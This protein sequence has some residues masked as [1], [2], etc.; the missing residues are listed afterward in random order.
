MKNDEVTQNLMAK[1][2]DLVNREEFHYCIDVIGSTTK[3]EGGLADLCEKIDPDDPKFDMLDAVCS[4]Y[5]SGLGNAIPT[6]AL[7]EIC[8]NI[9]FTKSLIKAGIRVD[10]NVHLEAGKDI[11]FEKI[12]RTTKKISEAQKLYKEREELRAQKYRGSDGELLDLDEA[13]KFIW[14]LKPVAK[15]LR[16]GAE[17]E[18]ETAF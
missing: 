8:K 5:S 16:Q 14:Q 11:G 4:W 3:S 15:K 1:Y 12:A 6:N 18:T 7:V 17:N 13:M 9:S 10:D 2:R